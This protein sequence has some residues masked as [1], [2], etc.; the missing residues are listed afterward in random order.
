MRLD[1]LGKPPLVQQQRFEPAKPD[2][3]KD[4]EIKETKSLD[5]QGTSSHSGDSSR[6]GKILDLLK[7]ANKK[8]QYKGRANGAVKAYQNEVHFEKLAK[9]GQTL[10][11]WV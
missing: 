2:K 7:R 10:D 9:C 3:L 4:V 5:E 6:L 1:S 8:H 11:I